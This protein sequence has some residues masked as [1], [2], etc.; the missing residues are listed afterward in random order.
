MELAA[1]YSVRSGEEF[2]NGRHWSTLLSKDFAVVVACPSIHVIHVESEKVNV[3]RKELPALWWSDQMP[4]A[5]PETR[6]YYFFALVSKTDM[7]VA[8]IS[9]FLAT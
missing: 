5:I 8:V 4:N 3:V 7:K 1:P 9:P 6:N 2:C